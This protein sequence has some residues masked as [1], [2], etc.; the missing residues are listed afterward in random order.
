MF[1]RKH[2]I[3]VLVFFVTICTLGFFLL[4]P[5]MPEEPIKV[6]KVTTPAKL[7]KTSEAAKVADDGDT[8]PSIGD[9]S[10]GGHWHGDEWHADAR[11]PQVVSSEESDYLLPDEVSWPESTKAKLVSLRR[12][13]EKGAQLKASLTT[14]EAQRNIE[15][16]SFLPLMD[17]IGARMVE[18]SDWK[19]LEGIPEAEYGKIYSRAELEAFFANMVKYAD[20]GA[21]LIDAYYAYPA[22]IEYEKLV[23]PASVEKLERTVEELRTLKAKADKHRYILDA[24]KSG[25]VK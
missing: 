11:T 6:Y 14:L 8:Q 2:W 18:V 17:D 22:I 3:P 19:V 7:A 10:Q 24:R 20:L 23:R 25:G 1:I 12:K 15:V 4:H 5:N 16:K 13:I 9:T 21:E